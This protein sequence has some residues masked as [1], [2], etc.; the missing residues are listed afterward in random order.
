MLQPLPR[1]AQLG[2]LGG[3]EGIG[4]GASA[5][6]LARRLADVPGQAGAP[7]GDASRNAPDPRPS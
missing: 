7:G 1:V 3:G 5:S 2:E 4:Q 6:M